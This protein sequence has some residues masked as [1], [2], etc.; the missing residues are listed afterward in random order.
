MEDARNVTTTTSGTLSLTLS[1]ISSLRYCLNWDA[2]VTASVVLLPIII[3]PMYFVRIVV[4]LSRL[5]GVFRVET[6]Q[7][8]IETIVPLNQT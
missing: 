2:H 4:F 8:E 6:G 3:V 5:N 1:E 7:F